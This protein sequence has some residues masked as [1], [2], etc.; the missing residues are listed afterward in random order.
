MVHDEAVCCVNY[1][2]LHEHNRG[3]RPIRGV[4][5]MEHR[6]DVPIVRDHIVVLEL[7]AIFLYNV[8]EF[9]PVVVIHEVARIDVVA[10]VLRVVVGLQRREI[11]KEV[12]QRVV[13]R[14]LP[15][16]E[17]VVLCLGCH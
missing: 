3:V 16:A 12:G 17:G 10:V 4:D 9:E 6:Q 11:V 13:W 7:K 15:V 1:A 5:D 14:R 8:F 2:M